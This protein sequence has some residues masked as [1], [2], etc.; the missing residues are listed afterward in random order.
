MS[1]ETTEP[2]LFAMTRD[3]TIGYIAQNVRLLLRLAGLTDGGNATRAILVREARRLKETAGELA[4]GEVA[5][6]A[7]AV[8][9]AARH[10]GP[11]GELAHAI[12]DLT[13]AVEH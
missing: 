1:P 8:E 7:A 3:E 6:A 5:E 12:Q 4:L 11:S 2:R 13:T 9:R 10:I